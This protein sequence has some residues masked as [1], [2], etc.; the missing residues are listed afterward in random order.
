MD[1]KNI[2][3]PDA[4]FFAT[5]PAHA[6]YYAIPYE[7]T[8][9]GIQKTVRQGDVHQ[10]AVKKSL[11]ID[12]RCHRRMITVMLGDQTNLVAFDQGVARASSD[13]FS[14]SDGI[15]SS[16]GAGAIDTAIVFQ[17]FA[18]RKSCAY[19]KDLLSK[20]SGF[21]ALAGSPNTLVDIIVR[22]DAKARFAK[23]I[24]CYQVLKSIGSLV[25]I[26]GGLDAIVFI[27]EPFWGIKNLALD[28]SCQ[29]KF[30]GLNNRSFVIGDEVGLLTHEDSRVSAYYFEYVP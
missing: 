16:T 25:A 28:L 26:L 20:E 17:L 13:G 19:I 12:H 8:R 11:E 9:Q 1:N 21:L 24:Y 18:A 30:L 23:E 15:V 5:I 7:Q 22:E 3:A 6:R 29:M 2:A 14:E 4:D 10:W 27:G